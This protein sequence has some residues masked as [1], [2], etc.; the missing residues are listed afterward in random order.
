MN[1]KQLSKYDR[2]LK[3]LE[4]CKGKVLSCEIIADLVFIGEKATLLDTRI[5]AKFNFLKETRFKVG[6]L[7]RPTKH[8]TTL[9]DSL[10]IETFKAMTE[11]SAIYWQTTR[12]TQKNKK[13]NKAAGIAPQ[14]EQSNFEPLYQL[15]GLYPRSEIK[16]LPAEI[17]TVYDINDNKEKVNQTIRMDFKKSPKN[18]PGTSVG[19]VW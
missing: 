14:I 11:E 16:A 10:N 1:I 7:G 5:L 6:H 18:Y 2:Y 4:V 15:L 8:Y 17:F 12:R 3:I 9:I 19:M 13:Q